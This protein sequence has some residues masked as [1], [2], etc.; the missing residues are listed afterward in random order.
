MTANSGQSNRS[1]KTILEE[2]IEEAKRA[3]K[4][5]NALPQ[6]SP[7]VGRVSPPSYSLPLILLIIL[8]VALIGGL[9]LGPVRRGEIFYF[10]QQA[11][12]PSYP[13]FQFVEARNGFVLITEHQKNLTSV[14]LQV[15]GE[16]IWRNISKDDFTVKNP[17]LSSDGSRVAYLSE[18]DK[19]HIVITSL[20]TEPQ[21]VLT[22]IRLDPKLKTQNIPTIICP[23][24][25][26]RWSP[27]EEHIAFFACSDQ[28]ASGSYAVVLNL[29]TDPVTVIW[30]EE[31]E[32]KGTE[33][34]LIW[35][36]KANLI[37]RTYDAEKDVEIIKME[38]IP[39]S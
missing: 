10:F 9:V 11:I 2:S 5:E 8:L 31:N 33:R 17:A 35:L 23:W 34:D 37:I 19:P 20:I 22:D 21:R 18:K 39:L 14:N 27:D 4:Q 15:A 3:I 24:S 6:T 26:I 29:N 12:Q 13:R 36:D 16:S 25:G 38:K 7:R 32:V 30:S 28:E 1:P